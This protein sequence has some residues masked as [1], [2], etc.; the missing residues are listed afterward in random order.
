VSEPT[1]LDIHHFRLICE[2][3]GM[4]R[5]LPEDEELEA[6][7]WSSLV[8]EDFGHEGLREWS[9]AA[10]T[11]CVAR[12]NEAAGGALFVSEPGHK[13]LLTPR[14]REY[15]KLV[16]DVL[17]LHEKLRHMPAAGDSPPRS[18]IVGGF[19]SLLASHVPQALKVYFEEM[20]T[21]SAPR[22]RFRFRED[23][24]QGL[25]QA[26]ARRTVDFAVAA[27]P[28]RDRDK[29]ERDVVITPLGYKV[30]RGVI[31]PIGH[32]LQSNRRV[33][34]ED[35]RHETIFRLPMDATTS[36][37]REWFRNVV[38]GGGEVVEVMNFNSVLQYVKLG[39]G[40]ATV[41]YLPGEIAD[42]VR[43]EAVLYRSL[44]ELEQAEI[45]LF[46]PRG[47]R[48]VLSIPGQIV[49]DVVEAYF[50]KNAKNSPI[51]PANQ[52]R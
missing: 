30:E 38:T 16:V 31:L 10:L 12:L 1:I 35:L 20:K 3:L 46:L 15:Y 36:S 51:R 25:V 34:L 41:P 4:R 14:G 9:V 52:R 42:A 7:S 29:T 21:G 18:V 22:I 40:V 8:H 33:T 23:T 17:E 48:A 50:R 37:P 11:A 27:V 43:S 49:H 32:R 6:A 24:F 5:D 13:H 47:G 45:A 44:S 39:L 28:V 19:N 2:A 26:V